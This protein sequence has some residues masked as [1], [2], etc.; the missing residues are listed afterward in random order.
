VQKEPP[1]RYIEDKTEAGP[2]YEQKRWEEEHLHAALLKFGAK[3][4]KSASKVLVLIFFSCLL[5]PSLF[6]FW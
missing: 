4:A 6:A 5:G 1:H 2:N 3:D